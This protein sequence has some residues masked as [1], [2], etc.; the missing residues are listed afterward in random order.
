M[1]IKQITFLEA[2]KLVDE[3]NISNLFIEK[4]GVIEMCDLIELTKAEFLKIPFTEMAGRSY[5][6]LEGE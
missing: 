2:M 3:G 6:I 5:F 1:N 4:N